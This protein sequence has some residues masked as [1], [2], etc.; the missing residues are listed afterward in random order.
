MRVDKSSMPNESESF[1]SYQ[2]SSSFGRGLRSLFLSLTFLE[3]YP[4]LEIISRLPPVK[5]SGQTYFCSDTTHFW[6]DKYPLRHIS[7]NSPPSPPARC[8]HIKQVHFLRLYCQ[9]ASNSM[10]EKWN[11]RYSR[12]LR[13]NNNNNNNN[14][15]NA[16]L[17]TVDLYHAR[18]FPIGGDPKTLTPGPWTSP[19]G[20][21]HGPPHGPVHGQPIRTAPS[22]PLKKKY[23]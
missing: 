17:Y 20:R 21:V 5:L 16:I 12:N 13:Q 2:L 18:W 3:V 10:H 15:N 8:L 1:N 7:I 22:D 23:E 6:Q 11:A 19:T 4:G 14:S 9:A